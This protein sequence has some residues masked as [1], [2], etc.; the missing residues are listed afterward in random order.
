MAF[1]FWV[2]VLSILGLGL[3]ELYSWFKQR[4]NPPLELNPSEEES[5]EKLQAELARARMKAAVLESRLQEA[6][7]RLETSEAQREEGSAALLAQEE[8]YRQQ[9]VQTEKAY[10]RQMVT[11]SER[12]S[13]N[14][15]GK[16]AFRNEAIVEYPVRMAAEVAAW[17]ASV[18]G[19]PLVETAVFNDAGPLAHELIETIDAPDPAVDSAFEETA[20][21]LIEMPPVSETPAVNV[22][23]PEPELMEAVVISNGLPQPEEDVLDQVVVLDEVPQVLVIEDQPVP[24]DDSIDQEEFDN[25]EPLMGD[26]PTTAEEIALDEEAAADLALSVVEVA[27]VDQGSRPDAAVP[28]DE[29]SGGHDAEIAEQSSDAVVEVP[30][31]AAM[32]AEESANDAY[33][34]VEE[35]PPLENH[36][37]DDLMSIAMQRVMAR[38]L[39]SEMDADYLDEAE[40]LRE[41]GIEPEYAQQEASAKRE[42]WITDP[43]KEMA[44]FL[45][46][47]EPDVNRES[48]VSTSANNHPER[49]PQQISGRM[50]E[51]V[52]F[53]SVD[54]PAKDD[55]GEHD[56]PIGLEAGNEGQIMPADEDEFEFQTEE[57]AIAAAVASILSRAPDPAADQISEVEEPWPGEEIVAT[58][59]ETAVYEE[60]DLPDA[61][62]EV[63]AIERAENPAVP[64]LEEVQTAD[65][66]ETAEP[67]FEWQREP[68]S[69]HAEYFANTTLSDKPFLVRQDDDINFE[70]LGN[71]PAKGLDPH[72]FSVRWSGN[73]L[74]EPGQYRFMASAPDGLR[75]WLNDRLVISAWYDQ[76]EQTYQRDFA[77]PGGT[78]DVRVEHYENGGDAKALMTWERVA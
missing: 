6:E 78:I 1:W 8:R 30:Q 53:S 73:L 56:L 43:L 45:N 51:E 76:S 26:E 22:T 52:I 35:I 34:P 12:L 18:G 75:L 63:E 50:W 64:G 42:S 5:A 15:N 71:S 36:W 23:T 39:G 29:T 33:A 69:W 9:L 47:A 2:V 24:E 55:P 41:M 49:R 16:S 61:E 3:Y 19:Q 77:W 27:P 66:P 32:A 65:I 68:I 4:N 48:E 37:S 21:S 14:G 10:Q 57:E 17:K 46:G 31:E 13:A 67:A 72:S 40:F 44:N 20:D 38:Q 59:E 58:V 70:W 62:N 74:L 11:L 7:A 25:P 60:A 28:M 54:P